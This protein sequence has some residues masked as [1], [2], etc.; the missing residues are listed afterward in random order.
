MIQYDTTSLPGMDNDQ[1]DV[2]AL[3]FS[4]EEY[5]VSDR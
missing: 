3:I 4:N 2:D 5:Y 1:G